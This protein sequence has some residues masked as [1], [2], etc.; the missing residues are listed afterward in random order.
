L[1]KSYTDMWT[2]MNLDSEDDRM[3]YAA[4]ARA[5]IDTALRLRPDGGFNLD[6]DELRSDSRF[7]KLVMQQKSKI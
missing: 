2:A 6:W 4:R 5:T 7:E 3:L 1:A